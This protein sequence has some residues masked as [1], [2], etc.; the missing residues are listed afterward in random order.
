MPCLSIS[1]RSSSL[2]DAEMVFVAVLQ[3]AVR[4]WGR[5]PGVSPDGSTPVREP[6]RLDQVSEE[7]VCLTPLLTDAVFV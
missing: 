4:W 5:I 7:M 3:A 2:C 1:R 6:R